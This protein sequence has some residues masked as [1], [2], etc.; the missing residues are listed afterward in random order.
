MGRAPQGRPTRDR[1][2]YGLV[3]A[4]AL[5]VLGIARALTPS[6][7]GMGTHEQLGMPPCTFL[8]LTGHGC[9]GC[10]MTTAFALMARG[11][12]GAAFGANPLGPVLFALTAFA[13]AAGL[14]LAVRPAIGLDAVLESRYLPWG[15][16]GL[17][18]AM[19]VVW[20]LRLA[21]GLA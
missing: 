15:V 18:A 5:A 7:S 12:V 21:L 1:A 20:A 9:P 16:V 3:A 13:A 4:A 19:V 14:V 8:L 17:F 10:G 2:G 6:P 11:E